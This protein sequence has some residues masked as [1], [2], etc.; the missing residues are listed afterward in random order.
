MSQQR[1]HVRTVQRPARRDVYLTGSLAAPVADD[2]G[3]V[4]VFAELGRAAVSQRCAALQEKI[5]GRFADHDRILSARRRGY[6]SAGF[7]PEARPTFI[8]GAPCVGGALAGVQLFGVV[9]GGGVTV[10]T[11]VAEGEPVGRRMCAGDERLVHLAGVSGAPVRGDETGDV[12]AQAERM[13]RRAVA[14]LVAEGLE[15]TDIVRTWIYVPRILEW[16]GELNRVRTA[17]FR[18]LGL[19]GGREVRLLPA[20]T[21]IRG[22]RAEGEE[23]FMDVLAVRGPERAMI[24]N[25][26]QNEAWEYGSSFSRGVRV[27]SDDMPTL[28]ISGTASIDT[29]GETVHVGDPQ[30]QVLETILDVASLLDGQST[31]LRDICHATAFCKDEAAYDSFRR[32]VRHLE[33]DDIPFVPVWA[34]VCRD[35]LLFEID[36]LAV[37]DVSSGRSAR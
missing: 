5:H 15:A 10:E 31:R 26:R 35:D 37:T 14:L 20:S 9:P 7:D 2:E 28:Y 22:R 4:A 29:R 30:A 17:Y 19:L 1:I 6:A 11:I 23:C 24:H 3:L 13:F 21:G 34:D 16:Y 8:D 27:Q 12:S 32:I 33:L 25:A 36:C 18:E